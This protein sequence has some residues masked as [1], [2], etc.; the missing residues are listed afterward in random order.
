MRRPRRTTAG[1]APTMPSC[2]PTLIVCLEADPATA[3]APQHTSVVESID[4]PAVAERLSTARFQAERR[5]CA[6]LLFRPQTAAPGP[7]FRTEGLDSCDGN[8][9]AA[10][11]AD[12]PLPPVRGN[13][14]RLRRSGNPGL[15]A[16]RPE[17]PHPS[18]SIPPR[19]S[20]RR[21][22]F[23]SRIDNQE[24]PHVYLTE[25]PSIAECPVLGPPV[26]PT[27]GSATA[28]DHVSD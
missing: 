22:V 8:S 25:G 2:P 16:P 27:P 28:P 5:R 18:P 26:D 14:H 15:P 7:S 4:S 6:Q 13:G 20:I 19:R 17:P 10:P 3:D 24:L 12:L 21:R 1:T 9:E 23:G 11:D